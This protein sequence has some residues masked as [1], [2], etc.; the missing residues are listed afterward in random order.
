MTRLLFKPTVLPVTSP[1]K[2]RR[3]GRDE[4]DAAPMTVDGKVLGNLALS[5]R[6]ARHAGMRV[7]DSTPR[8]R[9]TH[10]FVGTRHYTAFPPRSH[11]LIAA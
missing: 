7:D 2:A 11:H 3:H 10:R 6:H 9:V 8:L 4:T 5:V 1:A